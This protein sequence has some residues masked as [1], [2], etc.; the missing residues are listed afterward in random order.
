MASRRSATDRIAVARRVAE[1]TALNVQ[2]RIELRH[3]KP[4]VWRCLLV[5]ERVTLA[6][7]HGIVQA[8]MGW[9]Y[10]HLHEFEIARQRYGTPDDDWPDSAPVIDERRVRLQS[11]IEA[12]TKRFTYIYDFGDYWEHRIVVEDLVIPRPGATQSVLCLAGENACPPEDVGGSA[13][14]AEFLEALNDPDHEEH[15]RM[16]TWIGGSF[17][18]SAFNL[19]DTNQILK[20]IKL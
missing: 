17:D 14:Y 7:L 3:V 11:L 8:A 6:K 5:P 20:S 13:G 15:N 16:I 18:P 4:A 1:L 12:G 19:G 9:G 10:G 2:L